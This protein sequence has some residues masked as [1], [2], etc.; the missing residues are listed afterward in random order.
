MKVAEQSACR[1]PVSLLVFIST[2]WPPVWGRGSDSLLSQSSISP[3]FHF[4]SPA[5]RIKSKPL[6]WSS[7][8]PV[9][10]LVFISTTGMI[11]RKSQTGCLSQSSI[12]PGF[13]FDCRF[14][15]ATK[16]QDVTHCLPLT[17]IFANN[18]RVFF[19]KIRPFF[20]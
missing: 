11:R 16:K 12:S 18:F 2:I 17:H 1:N 8:N 19:T 13:H 10:L 20:D 14:K 5:K 4:D 7:R 15:I 3:G 6:I 9:S